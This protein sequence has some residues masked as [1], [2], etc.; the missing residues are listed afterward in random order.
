MDFELPADDDPRRQAVRAW[1][2]EHPSPSGRQLA[3][4]GYVA[5][6]WPSP[7]GLDADPI[8][9]LVIDD[10]L[11]RAGV[12]LFD[13]APLYGS[14]LSETRLGRALAGVPR[15]AFQV[16]TKV[17]RLL[18]EGGAGQPI[19]VGAPALI[20]VYDFSADGVRRSLDASLERLGLD[21]VDSLLLHDPDDHWEQAIGEAYPALERLRADGVVRRIGAGMNQ[22]ALLA[23]FAGETDLDVVMMGGGLTLL[24]DS[25]LDELVPAAGGRAVLA[26]AP[27]NSG[28][29]AGG[30]TFFYGPIPAW[31]RGKVKAL[32]AVCDR[33]DVP[34]AA[35]ALQYPLRHVEAV[36]VG[37]RSPE[38]VVENERLAH[39]P[40]PPELWQELGFAGLVRSG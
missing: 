13:T 1:L 29:L 6:H 40:L 20:P 39:L 11:R 37:S 14:G 32:R 31:V 10:E 8:H 35:A 30:D 16:Q 9:Q 33:F 28:V 7:W 22:S 34:L 2:T 5:P 12:H 21:R 17:G 25:A 4:A 19:F 24:D 15:D 18:V 26:A 23:R 36:V 27:F 38:E 3:E